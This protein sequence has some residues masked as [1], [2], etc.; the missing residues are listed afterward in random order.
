MLLF[1]LFLQHTL[2]LDCYKG[3]KQKK[4]AVQKMNGKDKCKIL[5]EIRRQ[6]AENNDIEWVVSECRHQGTCKGTCPRCESEVRKLERELERKRRLGQT[7]AIAG[8][9]AACIAGLTAC[10]G[11][12]LTGFFGIPVTEP[13]T[14]VEVLDGEIAS[15]YDEPDEICII[16]TDPETD[17][18]PIEEIELSGDVAIWDD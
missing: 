10:S 17:A 14:Y 12:P 2:L 13:E 9:S 5:K 18:V 1:S 4:K 15:F 16:E 3:E 6:I 7:V 11:T 8:I